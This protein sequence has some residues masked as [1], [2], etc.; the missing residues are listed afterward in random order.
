MSASTWAQTASLPPHLS[1]NQPEQGR[2]EPGVYGGESPL[3]GWWADASPEA[4]WPPNLMLASVTDPLSGPADDDWDIFFASY[5]W[6]FAL[7]GTIA[8]GSV[9]AD[10]DVS[11]SDTIDQ[12]ENLEGAFIGRLEARKGR[13]F[14]WVDVVYLNLKVDNSTTLANID[15]DFKQTIAELGGGYELLERQIGEAASQTIKLDVMGGGR[16]N[17]LQTDVKIAGKGPFGVT[18]QKDASVD[19]VDPFVGGRVRAQLSDDVFLVVRGDV[20]GFGIGSASDLTWQVEAV[21]RVLLSDRASLVAGYRVLDIDL[22][23][24]KLQYDVQMHGPML[25]LLFEF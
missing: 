4:V 9:S 25:G 17:H 16:Y 20:G 21:I 3:D 11:L 1:A 8:A 24:S 2:V 15:V 14:L 23:R 12:L 6:L 19:W 13:G 18:V 10:V 7:D 22:D 5:G